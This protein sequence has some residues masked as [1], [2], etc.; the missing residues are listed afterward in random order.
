MWY[1]MTV[2]IGE[3]YFQVLSMKRSSQ[4]E[5]SNAFP[6]NSRHESEEGVNSGNLETYEAMQLSNSFQ[7]GHEICLE[8]CSYQHSI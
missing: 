2:K 5:S 3:T 8:A 4:K 1:V 6:H 7:L